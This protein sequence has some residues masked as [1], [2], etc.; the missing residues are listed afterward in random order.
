MNI[1]TFSQQTADKIHFHPKF[2][3]L[4]P[5]IHVVLFYFNDP[6]FNF[7]FSNQQQP[8]R[9][10]QKFLLVYENLFRLCFTLCLL[11][12]WEEQNLEFNFWSF[13]CLSSWKE[14]ISP[15]KKK[16]SSFFPTSI[17]VSVFCMLSSPRAEPS[18]LPFARQMNLCVNLSQILI[19]QFGR[20]AAFLCNSANFV[21]VLISL[22][23]LTPSSLI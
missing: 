5:K 19:F 4:L 8:H 15:R 13:S 22:S 21:S 23:L 11:K 6:E 17:F 20:P 12:K 3:L 10:S 7:K 1:S 14:K 16:I 9:W 2:A 18:L